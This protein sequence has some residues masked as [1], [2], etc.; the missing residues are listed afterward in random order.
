MRTQDILIDGQT[1]I[2]SLASIVEPFIHGI[3]PSETEHGLTYALG[4]YSITD[5]EMDGL[6]YEDDLGI[7]LSHYR[8]AIST[9]IDNGREWAG[10]VYEALLRHT[11]LNLLWVA[12]MQHVIKE[13]TTL[14]KAKAGIG[15]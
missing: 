2:E 11:D 15:S 9:R 13:R 5:A 7:P 6:Y 14:V 12:D 3:V 8:F 10:Q 4:V 1:S